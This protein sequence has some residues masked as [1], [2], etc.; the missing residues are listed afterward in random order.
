MTSININGSTRGEVLASLYN[1]AKP[2]GMGFLH[3]DPSGMTPEEA[4][5]HLSNSLYIGWI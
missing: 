1:N 5:K 4:E 2:M 3:F